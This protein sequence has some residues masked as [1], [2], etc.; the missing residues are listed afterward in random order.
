MKAGKGNK[1]GWAI[2]FLFFLLG[3]FYKWI[4][5]KRAGPL[6]LGDLYFYQGLAQAF[7][8]RDWDHFRHFHFYP[9]YPILM[10]MVH[11]LT[12]LDLISSARWLNI[13]F[14]G[15]SL[16]PIYLI[17]RSLY[18]SRAG[19]FSALFWSLGWPLVRVYGDPEP[20]YGFFI[21]IGLVFMFRH[22]L[23]IRNYLTAIA[24]AGFAGL[25]KSEA[26]LFVL[27]FTLMYLVQGREN[28]RKK[29]YALGSA[30]LIYLAL[31]SPLWIRYYQATGRFN[32]NP[33]SRTLFFIHNYQ[34]DYQTNLYGLKEDG[35]G[36]YS[37]AQRIYI[38][39]DI[40]PIRGS[41]VSYFYKNR[42]LF[43]LSYLDKLEFALEKDLP[44]LM[45]RIFPGSF[46]LILVYWL[47][48]K[49]NFEL[50]REAWVWFWGLSVLLSVSVFDVW[51][52]FFYTFFPVLIL[53]SAKGLDQ[54]MIR[55]ESLSRRFFPES[56]LP[57][58][59]KWS[60]AGIFIFW[61]V[62][63]NLSGVSLARPDPKLKDRFSVKTRLARDLKLKIDLDAKIMCR[64]FPEPIAYFLGLP[65][66]KM[67]ILPLA[68]EDELLTYA[69]ESGVKYMFFE[70]GD[71]KR[72]PYAERWIYGEMEAGGVKRILYIPRELKDEYYPYS[73]Y[74]LEKDQSR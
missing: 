35:Y 3:L 24:L 69:R 67:V 48:R 60:L 37:D 30:A 13:I 56:T 57:G 17:G 14:D 22:P 46:F 16:I 64:G 72:N 29:I 47:R 42:R 20:V 74:E 12:G 39:G 66:W 58:I 45:L 32:P 53:L 44:F 5:L 31:T 21:F 27:F 43:F 65:F 61:F 18:G 7:L 59:I 2:L 51:E 33:K 26:M 10:A 9:V 23:R 63:Y 19:I 50:E 54:V 1:I 70:E 15:L 11:R 4:Y 34:G 62:I 28:F 38:E 41:L 73:F 40:R 25:I 8:D 55:A 6:T 71:L 36:L 52:R 68:K 49:R